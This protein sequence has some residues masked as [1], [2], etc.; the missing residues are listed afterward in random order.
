[1]RCADRTRSSL[2]TPSCVSASCAFATFGTSFG[3]PV[4]MATSGEDSGTFDL[5]LV[6]LRRGGFGDGFGNGVGV[7]VGAGCSVVHD[8]AFISALPP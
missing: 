8:A 1:M 3:L 6:Q 5:L 4:R 2:A 7:G